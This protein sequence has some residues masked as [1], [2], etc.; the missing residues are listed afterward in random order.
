MLL[1]ARAGLPLESR[2]GTFTLKMFYQ[3][4]GPQ[5]RPEAGLWAV[6]TPESGA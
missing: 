4:P 5:A 1:G 3:L 6:D 2:L